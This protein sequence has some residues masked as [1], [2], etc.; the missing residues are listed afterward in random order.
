MSVNLSVSLL[1]GLRV[2]RFDDVSSLVAADASGQ[3]GLW[4]G[5]APLVTVLE[6]GLFRLRRAAAP[7]WTWGACVG[8]LLACERG[9]GGAEVRIVSRRF[10][11]EDQPEALQTRLA[12]ALQREGAWR[13]STRENRAQLDLALLRRLEQLT[14]LAQSSA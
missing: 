10:L 6:P 13:V 8:G 5:H 11:L 14:Q 1:D 7:D 2:V 4:P 12:E 3:F 9:P